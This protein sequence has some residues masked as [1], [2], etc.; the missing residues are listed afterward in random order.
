MDGEIP[1]PTRKVG[2]EPARVVLRDIGG[3]HLVAA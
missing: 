3:G 2:D 1:S